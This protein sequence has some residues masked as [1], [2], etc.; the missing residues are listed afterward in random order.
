MGRPAPETQTPENQSQTSSLRQGGWLGGRSREGVAYG[1]RSGR[2]RGGGRRPGRS[3]VIGDRS[4]TPC[5]GP[6]DPKKER[7]ICNPPPHITSCRHP[8]VD[9]RQATFS[10]HRWNTAADV[11]VDSPSSVMA[12][13]GHGGNRCSSRLR[14]WSLQK[15]GKC[16]GGTATLALWLLSAPISFCCLGMLMLKQRGDEAWEF[17]VK[18]LGGLNCGLRG[19]ASN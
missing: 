12:G 18:N 9:R 8:K 2:G 5:I 7:N 6:W 16:L 13:T 4:G 11:P 17:W 14:G 15:G 19:P 10:P 3:G 1:S